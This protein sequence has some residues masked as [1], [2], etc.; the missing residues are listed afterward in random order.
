MTDTIAA[1][2]TGAAKSA[3]AIIR[4]SG[5]DTR[6]AVHAL[7]GMVPEARRASVRTLR[8]AAS[9][10]PL[11]EAVV[12][13]LPAPASFTGED[14]AEFH[15]HG[16]RAVVAALLDEVTRV[17]G[18]RLAAAGEFT[19][20]AVGNGRLDLTEA[21]GIADLIDAETAGQRRLA[22]NQARGALERAASGWRGRVVDLLALVEAQIDFADEDDVPDLIDVITARAADL[23]SDVKSAL[24]TGRSG[25]RL[26]SGAMVVIAGPPNAGKSTLMNAIARRDVAIVSPHAGTTRDI[27]EVH[28]DLDGLP[29][30]LVDT[31]GIRRSGDLVESLGIDRARAAIRDADL[32]L[33]LS[34]ADN[35][36]DAPADTPSPIIVT[37]KA[38]LIDSGSARSPEIAVCAVSGQGL[39]DLLDRI[40][41]AVRDALEGGETALVTRARHRIELEAMARHLAGVAEFRDGTPIE[42]VAEDL[43]LCVRA[44][45]R[46]T[47]TV[48]IDEIHDVIFS[49]FCIGK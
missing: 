43:R 26:R 49:S 45:G 34:P 46:L 35:P 47:G 4:L 29:V 36:V 15:V 21:E 33:W 48:D 44:I 22:L 19:R 8:R 24:A 10:E 2:S 13:F 6:H 28:L 18:V 31:A 37:T 25:E 23:L 40:R 11:D 1:L 9:G 14:M 42:F 27:I 30:T 32:V 17:P 41:M 7:C 16:G 38:D 3:I 39:A 12:L 5:P 20:R